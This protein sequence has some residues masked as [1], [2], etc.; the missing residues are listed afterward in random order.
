[1]AALPACNDGGEPGPMGAMGTMGLQGEP[2]QRGT[3]GD[4]G[5]KGDRG[6]EGLAGAKGERGDKGDKGDAGPT[7]SAGP[8][9][10]TGP[11]G[12]PGM[13]GDKGDRGDKGDPGIKGDK[14]DKG[15]KGLQGDRGLQGAKGDKGDPG[16]PGPPGPPGSGGAV[17]EDVPGFA[18]FTSASYNGKVTGGR[19]G[20]HALCATAFTGAHL[21]HAAE[22][23]Q[24]TSAQQPPTAGA[25]IDPSTVNGSNV[26]NNGSVKAGRLPGTYSC[27][28]WN[29][30]GGGDYGTIVTAT[31]TIDPYGACGTAR[32]LAC[33]NTPTKA[34]FAGFT[35][36]T[37][38]GA[39]G[40]RWKMHSLCATAFTGAHMCHAT[41][42]LRANSA[43]TVPSGGAWLDSSSVN[44]S[45]VAN[46]GVPDSSRY[47]TGAS[48]SSWNNSGG[49]DYGTVVTDV[50]QIDTYGDCARA[51]PVAC[52]L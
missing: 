29:N 34:R 13:K 44:G 37:V 22:Y 20:M 5:D 19:A 40:G 42:Y 12:I 48:C 43:Q 15:D 6:P 8:K 7:G 18:G 9:G 51:R 52:C 50:T 36:A 39:A 46:S 33:C 3:K 2:G 14:G 26:A 17:T 28:S 16:N 49:G 24:A 32:Q 4:K 21:C 10:D 23:V 1:M 27:S 11:T 47:I 45:T 25:W 31:G 35:S 38:H 30:S 41:E